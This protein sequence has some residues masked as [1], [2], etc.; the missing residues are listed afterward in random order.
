MLPAGE[1]LAS[2]GSKISVWFNGPLLFSP[3]AINTR[4][5]AKR[6]AVWPRR[7]VAIVELDAAFTSNAL[8]ADEA[9]TTGPTPTIVAALARNMRLS[10]LADELVVAKA[11]PA[12]ATKATSAASR[13]ERFVRVESVRSVERRRVGGSILMRLLKRDKAQAK[14]PGRK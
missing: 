3:P 11:I 7:S 8:L 14:Q 6:V 10:E 12:S 2:D 4:P 13:K 1:K 9:L 5:S